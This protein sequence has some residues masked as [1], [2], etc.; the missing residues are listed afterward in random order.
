M[1]KQNTI[2]GRIDA[3]VCEYFSMPKEIVRL[4]NLCNF[5]LYF[6]PIDEAQLDD[7]WERDNYKSFGEALEKIQAW[8]DENV[9]EV[10][11]DVDCDCVMTSEPEWH[12]EEDGEWIEP[13]LESTYQVSRSEVKE[14]L[15][16]KEL[17]GYV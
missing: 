1:T 11:V 8:I 5:D 17:G 16:G 7:Q 15:L 9:R 3:L 10:W 13:Y 2:R 4:R 6:G 14:Y 12:Q